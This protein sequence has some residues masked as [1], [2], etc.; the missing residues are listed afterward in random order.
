MA[1]LRGPSLWLRGDVQHAVEGLGAGVQGPLLP[2]V[3]HEV[4]ADVSAQGVGA[5]PSGIEA[6]E[7]VAVEA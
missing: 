1:G 3:R 5:L 6:D 4:E 7:L 2:L